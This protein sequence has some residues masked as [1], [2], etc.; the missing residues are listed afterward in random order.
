MWVKIICGDKQLDT[1]YLRN[2][3]IIFPELLFSLGVDGTDIFFKFKKI[4][5]EWCFHMIF[6]K[7]KIFYHIVKNITYSLLTTFERFLMTLSS[8]RSNLVNFSP[9]KNLTSNGS[10]PI[11]VLTRTKSWTSANHLRIG[12]L[13]PDFQPN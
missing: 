6:Y 3:L 7:K 5:I 12:Y 8:A 1:S 11:R 9:K 4:S 2:V 10:K 13:L